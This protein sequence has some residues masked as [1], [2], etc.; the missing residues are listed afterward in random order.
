M[1]VPETETPSPREVEEPSDLL[2]S[3]SSPLLIVLVFSE[4]P[5]DVPGNTL[6]QY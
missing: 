4:N 3:H 6:Q 1:E 5:E 2:L